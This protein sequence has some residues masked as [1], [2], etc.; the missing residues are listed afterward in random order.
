MR[1]SFAML[2][3]AFALI[4]IVGIMPLPLLEPDEGRYLSIP[5]EMLDSGDF[6]LPTI[7]GIP[8]LEKPP[9]HYWLTAS[10]L[11]LF[12]RHPWAGRVWPMLLTFLTALLIFYF[13]RREISILAAEVSTVLYL[14]SLYSLCLS[15]INTIDEVFGFF[16]TATVLCGYLF[17]EHK[18][19]RFLYGFWAAAALGFLSKGLAVGVLAGGAL[20]VYSVATR[21][22]F[23]WTRLFSL[24]PLLLFVV[25]VAPWLIAVECKLPG[26]LQFFIIKEH[27]ARFLTTVHKRDGPLYYFLPILAAGVIP[28]LGAFVPLFRKKFLELL[29]NRGFLLALCWFGFVFVFFSVSS[30][31]LP[32]YLTPCWAALCIVLG[33]AVASAEEGG[34]ISGVLGAL[35]CFAVATAM[36]MGPTEE[37]AKFGKPYEELASG[38][39]F[40]AGAAL[41]GAAGFASLRRASFLKSLVPTALFLALALDVFCF[42]MSPILRATRSSEP[43]GEIING[44]SSGPLED[45]VIAR[46]NVELQGLTFLT[47]RRFLIVDT[48]GELEFGIGK[49]PEEEKKRVYATREEFGLLWKSAQRVLAIMK[50]ERQ[51]EF[52]ASFGA[53]R[54]LGRNARYI[55]LLN[56]GPSVPRSE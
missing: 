12:G 17:L 54:L 19:K 28:W 56:R 18:E 4:Y 7:N 13:V 27:F 37:V 50:V 44:I 9:L 32:T 5:A 1:R 29:R 8:Y 45:T 21:R 48:P 2:L 10:S 40:F 43:I 20:L 33:T 31:K 11:A 53:G 26:S 23:L 25:I 42:A 41:A 14:S 15:R 16:V 24:L 46:Y 52:E 6:V 38:F 36:V 51:E 3:A 39:I 35:G 47:G 34:F 30:S 55:A 22:Y 49:L